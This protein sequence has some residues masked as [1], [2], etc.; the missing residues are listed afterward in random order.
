MTESTRVLLTCGEAD[1]AETVSTALEEQN[2]QLAVTTAPSASDGME[3]LRAQRFDCVVSTH[4]LPGKDGIEFLET[5]R[6]HYEQLPFVLYPSNG[7]E[8][9]AADAISADVTEYLQSGDG[10]DRHEPLARAIADAVAA[11]HTVTGSAARRGQLDQI[12][13]TVPG[14]VVQIDDAGQFVYANRRAKEV[15]GLERSEVT[16][17]TYNDPEWDIR[18]VHGDPI[19]DEELPFR[20]VW[21]SGEPLYNYRHSIRWPDGSEKM[22]SVSGGPLFD[23][24]G[25]VESA[26][27]SLTDITEQTRRERELARYEQVVEHLDDIATIID[28]DG[29]IEYVSPAVERV[30]GYE[31]DELIGDVGFGYQPPAAADAVADAI[32]DVLADPSE[33]RTVRTKFR[34]ADGSWCWVESTLRNRLDNE[35]IDGILVSSRE[36]GE[37]QEQKQRTQRREQQFSTL[38]R[39]TRQLLGSETPQQV[40]ETASRTAVDVLDFQLNGIHFYDAAAG[41]LSPVAVS[42]ASRDLFGEVPVI[43][44]GVAWRTFQSGEERI[45]NDIDEAEAVYNPETAVRSE[46]HL[47]LADHGVFI[48]SST[49]TNA[50]AETDIE[51]GRLLAAN[52]EAALKRISKEQQ[53]QSR[54]T[55][56]KQQNNRL[57]EFASIV[58]HDLKNPLN[59]AQARTEFLTDECDSTHVQPIEQSLDR[60]EE[61]VVDTLTLARQGNV[62]AETEPIHLTNLVG[63]CWKTVS[64]DDATIQVVDPVTVNGDRGRL[65]HVFENLFRNAVDHGGTDVTV[66]VG[67]TDDGIYVEDAGPGIPEADRETVFEPGHTSAEDGTGFGLTIVKRVAEAHGWEVTV[68]AGTDGGAR[69]E[70]TGVEIDDD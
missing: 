58:S 2:T 70:F 56:L 19:P 15:L 47:P 26:V 32:E 49:E 10:A 41:G 57:E 8:T 54:E 27:F 46:M 67:R 28:P 39:A 53:L 51:F 43:D 5:V 69:F 52:T 63:K 11:P 29:T 24:Q 44:D 22:L 6:E 64:T 65:Q 3:R 9:V 50:F 60:M 33:T 35:A 17:R 7:S 36:V 13:R 66:R 59:V 62:V 40:A 16:G 45:Y 20:Q 14:C 30:L 23:E 37:Q 55:E 68:V 34:R 18:N 38:H 42:E 61:I 48:I 12:L 4:D 31:P 21:D 1:V 25:T